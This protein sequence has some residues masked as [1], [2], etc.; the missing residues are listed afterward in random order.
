[1][2]KIQILLV[3]LSG[4]FLFSCTDKKPDKQ[5]TDPGKALQTDH[6]H[7]DSTAVLE[8][9]NGQKWVVSREMRPHLLNGVA[10]VRD[11]LQNKQ[12]DYKALAGQLREQNS[13][14]LNSCNMRGKGHEEL[15]KWLIPHMELVDQLEKATD[16]DEA[17][18]YVQQLEQSY[19]EYKEF[20][21]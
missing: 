19:L 3:V 11:Y 2:K 10:L 20:F 14:L 18:S 21:E 6:Q 4:I 7:S 5:V 9:N 16:Q 17:L 8:L 15:H 1:M 13:Q 12:T